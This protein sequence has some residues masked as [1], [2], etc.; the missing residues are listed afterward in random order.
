M[1]KQAND[2]RRRDTTNG[3][4]FAVLRTRPDAAL[5]GRLDVEAMAWS[6]GANDVLIP[7]TCG[8]FW[9][10]LNDQIAFGRPDV[11]DRYVRLDVKAI[12]EAGADM[13]PE[14][15]LMWHLRAEGIAARGL[16]FD[17][18]KRVFSVGRPLDP[19]KGDR[20]CNELD[21]YGLVRD[22]SDR[23]ILSG[24]VQRLCQRHPHAILV[25]TDVSA[26][27]RKKCEDHPHELQTNPDALRH[28]HKQEV[29]KKA[30]R[31]RHEEEEQERAERRE[32]A[33]FDK[34]LEGTLGR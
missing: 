17:N 18:A 22:C 9:L 26:A 10:G 33:A 2:L 5:F 27:D 32:A 6:L 1:I 24:N 20:V 19:R 23:T 28:A 14:T 16:H 13:H 15:V 4:F 3:P 7:E 31:K 29:R 11:I 8:N 12:V 21:G 30:L 25:E 34:I